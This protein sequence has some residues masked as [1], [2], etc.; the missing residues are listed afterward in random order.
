LIAET[1][2]TC[3]DYTAGSAL[4][5]N[6]V[7]YSENNGLIGNAAPGVFFYFSR[8]VAPSSSFTITLSQT[9]NNS[10][11]PFFGVKN[12]DVTVYNADCTATTLP[13]T[14]NEANG[15]AT[16][17]I[18]GATAG[19]VFI[20]RVKYETVGVEGVS[21]PSPTTVH[22]DFRTLI[23]STVVDRNGNGLDLTI[24]P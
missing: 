22:Y 16:V 14:I 12:T 13:V 7:F 11:V 4:A 1:V 2:S 9:N 21:L 3:G 17:Q 23:G 6:Q 24:K 20:L 5:L 19:R 10:S 8:V 15:Q 18:S